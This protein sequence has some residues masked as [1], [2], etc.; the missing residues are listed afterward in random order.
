MQLATAHWLKAVSSVAPFGCCER[1]SERQSWSV[2]GQAETHC[3]SAKQSGLFEQAAFWEQQ[4][5]SKQV[6]QAMGW[7]VM[8]PHAA[9]PSLPAHSVPHVKSLQPMKLSYAATA[10]CNRL[11]QAFLHVVSVGE[12]ALTQLRSSMHCA[13]AEHVAFTSQHVARKQLLQT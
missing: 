3:S 2:A 4:L 12:Q 9:P 7:K 13:F 10:F 6:L 1:Q 8:S 5:A 11:R